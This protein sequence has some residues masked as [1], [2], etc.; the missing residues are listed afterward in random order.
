LSV[1]NSHLIEHDLF[2]LPKQTASITRISSVRRPLEQNITFCNSAQS[3]QSSPIEFWPTCERH[4]PP[5]NE[6]HSIQEQRRAWIKQLRMMNTSYSRRA[7]IMRGY[8][9]IKSYSL[10]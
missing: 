8:L 2:A 4:D 1:T 3:K 5:P 6:L 7:E 9:R 10:G